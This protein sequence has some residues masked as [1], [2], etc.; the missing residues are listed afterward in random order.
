[1]RALAMIIG[2]LL[3]ALSALHVYWALGGVRAGS[4]I[5]SRPDGTP[6]FRPGRIATLAVAAALVVAGIL[7]IARAG[8]VS[9]MLPVAWIR[10]G[11]WAV[12][13]AFA[14]RTIGEFRYVGL[15]RRVGGTTFA[16]WDARL[17]TPLCFAV[18]AGTL[19]VAA[20]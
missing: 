6:L 3:C 18:A 10:V 20:S 9:P 17:F 16:R 5:P 8:I 13:A 2:G 19:V 7:V 14:A 1:M 12:A 15:F 11:T 4:A